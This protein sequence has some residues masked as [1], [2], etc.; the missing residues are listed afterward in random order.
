MKNRL[1][2]V[3]ELIQRELGVIIQRDFEFTGSLVTINDVD[4]T[5]DLKHCHVYLGVIG[6]EK[7]THDAV[8]ILNEK[9][10]MLQKRLMSRI[11]LRNT[12][13]LHFKLDDS[14]SRGVRV[15]RIMEDIDAQIGKDAW[16]TLVNEEDADK[17]EPESKP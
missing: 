7:G 16:K 6:S 2:R 12:P 13:H 1:A 5:P 17:P 4:I 8:T 10:P 11:T 14:I 9:R 3:N 15:T